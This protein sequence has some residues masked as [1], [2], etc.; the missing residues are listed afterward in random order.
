MMMDFLS[1]FALY[2]LCVLTCMAL[3]CRWSHGAQTPLEKSVTF[4]SQRFSSCAP[5]WLQRLFY[6]FLHRLF[7]QRTRL[8]L[9]LHLLL[10]CAVYAEFA[11]EVFGY[12]REMDTQLSS[13]IVPYVLLAVQSCFFYLCCYRDP[14]TVTKD[15]HASQV[16]V[17]LYDRRLFQ[18]GVSCSTCLLVKPARSKHCRVCNRCVQRFD[19]HCVWVNNCIGAQNYRY[20]LLYLLLTCAMAGDIAVLTADMLFHVVLQADLL[21]ARY[22]DHNGEQQPA[23]PRFIIQHLFLTFPRIVFMLGFLVF[24][25][26]LLAGYALFHLYLAVVNQT[27]NEWYKGRAWG[28]EHCYGIAGHQCSLSSVTASSFYNRGILRNLWEIFHPFTASVKKN[29]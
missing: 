26:V 8:F 15:N 27:S 12:C 6:K 14:G 13:L 7:H 11:Y 9:Y 20:F 3:V 2:V 18:P 28:C 19:H 16:R 1:L 24:V 25:F 22:I 21:H 4:V 23:G 29:K 10:E 5:R 17:Y